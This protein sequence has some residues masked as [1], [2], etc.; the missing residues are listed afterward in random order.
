MQISKRNLFL[1]G[2]LSA[3]SLGSFANLP[4]SGTVDGNFV[5]TQDVSEIRAKRQADLSFDPDLNR[6]SSL[7]G[8]YREKLPTAARKTA[9]NSKNARNASTRQAKQSIRR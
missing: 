5:P 2:V 6:L 9:R 8:R 3:F 1:I 4:L 7:Q